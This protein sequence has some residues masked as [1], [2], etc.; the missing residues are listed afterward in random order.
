[1]SSFFRKKLNLDQASGL[2]FHWRGGDGLPFSLLAIA[3]C[4]VVAVMV[5]LFLLVKVKVPSDQTNE[6]SEASQVYFI[7]RGNPQVQGLSQFASP[8]PTSW[9]PLSD[10]QVMTRV[11]KLLHERLLFSQPRHL[12]FIELQ[13]DGLDV[14]LPQ[15]TSQGE[16][17]PK[18][19]QPQLPTKPQAGKCQLHVE[20]EELSLTKRF[21]QKWEPFLGKLDWS[22]RGV[23]MDFVLGI[24]PDGLV[25]VCIP[26]GEDLVDGVEAWLRSQKFQPGEKDHLGKLRISLVEVNDD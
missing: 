26:L 9:D 13:D 20:S 12:D 10:D 19:G 4:S 15:V 14:S 16:Y 8:L 17:L 11:Q 23:K 5:F 21:P 18:L 6:V 1:M 25:V 3:F 22:R 2:A 7:D 24:D